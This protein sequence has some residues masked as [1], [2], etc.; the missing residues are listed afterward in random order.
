MHKKILI[1][2][3]GS[4]GDVIHSLPFLQALRDTYPDSELHWVIAGSLKGMLEGHPMIDRMWVI[5]KDTWKNPWKVAATIN[6]LRTLRTNLSAQKY[7]LV[8]DLQGL[9]RSGLIARLSGCNNVIGFK[10]AREGSPLFY[11]H[12]VEGGKDVHAVDRY[13]KVAHAMGCEISKKVT[14]PLY[15]SKE[16]PGVMDELPTEYAV[17]VPGARWITK[18]W[19]ASHFGRLS[20]LL[21][22]ATVILGSTGD[23][24]AAEEIV[25]SSKGKAISLAGKT[26]L[27]D[28]P[29]IIS[30]AKFV[31]SNDTG[32]MH[33]AAALNVWVYAII[34]PTEPKRTGP[35]GTNSTVIR[36]TLSC[37]P[38][39]KKKCNTIQCLR[40]LSF[41][42]VYEIIAERESFRT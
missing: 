7:T 5:E 12:L 22:V 37:M 13:L 42:T 17:T 4:Y 15:F 1:I 18:R 25:S 35:Y 20:A 27:A 23:I 29:W 33:T 8:V 11:N 40:D 36:Q 30:Q 9:L 38:C 19:P 31:V 21:P 28:I 16:R 3:P 10:E 39:F 2:K 41:H 6:E 32:P 14:F 24:P 26:K 34:G